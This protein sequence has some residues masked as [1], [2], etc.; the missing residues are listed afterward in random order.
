M[1]PAGRDHRIE[2]CR[3]RQKC[4]KTENGKECPHYHHPLLHKSIVVKIG[5][6]SLSNPQETLLPV[7]TCTIYG[8][9]G[10]QKQGNTLLDS[11]AQVSLIRE[12][13]AATLG[14]KGKDTSITITKVGEEEETIKTKV[15]K[16][17]VSSPDST[18]MFSIKAISIPC[19]SEDVSAVQL[20][21]IAKLL[22]LENE[23][24]R[25]GNGPVDLLI[26]IDHA[27]MHTGLRKQTDQLVVR[28]TPLG[29]V[30]FGGPLGDAQVNGRVYH[31]RF[32]APVEMSDFWKTETMGVE[33]KPC[34]CAADKLTQ[35]EREEAE[36][37]SKSCEKIG[38]QWMIPY[39]WKKDPVLLPDNKS[40]AMKRLEA[41][42]R[43]LKKDPEQGMAYDKQ[44]EEMKE[45]QFSRKLSKQE[46]DNYKGPVHYIPHH[47]VIRPEK[48]STPV[49][50][51]F[52]SSSVYQGHA[53]NDYWL[54]GPDLLNNLFG[55]ILRF[56]Q[57]E[58]AVMGD[59]SKMYHRV[60]IPERDQHVH[61][62]LWRNLETER[63]PDVYVKTVLTF[64]DKPAPAMAQTALRK[65]AEENK[66]DHPEAAEALTKNSYMD[67]ICGSVD[68]VMQAQK[69]TGDLDKVLESGGFGVK[70]WTSNKALT[71][72]EDQERGLKVFQKEVEE[73][74]LGVVWNYHTDEFSF[75]VKLDLLRM[76]DRSIHLGVKM[77]KRTLLSQ[78][79]RFY[80]P[81]G[82]AAAFV[83]RA[84][85]SMQELWQIGLDWD[86]ELPDDVQERWIQLFKEMQELDKIGF[87]RCL[88]P[89]ESSELP[90]LCVFS[91]ASQEA[92]VACAYIHQRRNEDTYS[93]NFVA[94]K[95]RVAPLKQL[96][97]PR[98]ELQAAVLASRLAKTIV[99]ECTIQF[100]DIKFFTDSSITLAWIQ[101]PSRSFKPFVSSRVGEIQ[102]N[103]DPSQWRHISGED[104]VADDLSRGLHVQQ[105]TGRWMN[106]PEF[107]KL[108][109]EQWPV[110]TATPHREED[111]ERR[112]VNAVSSVSHADV[113][114][115]IDV[116]N[117]T[118]W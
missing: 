104:N 98:L 93:V 89:S 10:F 69:L 51:V 112:Q 22:G 63:E 116:K 40:L 100:A 92:F 71:K 102:S 6:A 96:T 5:V 31:V 58:V 85:I 74:V 107:L 42:E 101:S 103:S 15:Y 35:A 12:E 83:I 52:N 81:I 25:R 21:P 17:P 48:K 99:E 26:G 45:M 77:T 82:F 59:I 65:T 108:P 43:R 14:L 24:I 66:N 28:N 18:K 90:V 53:L 75:K 50:I 38:N 4:T 16:V 117:F 115:I 67:D 11:G 39:P 55:V 33:V 23:R 114:K 91:D 88:V 9:N 73:K 37:I 118:R 78:V 54:K 57:K 20:K 109:E 95:S 60:L 32:A 84:K 110:Q 1:K 97:I 44:M 80:D 56:R 7:I 3:R 41:T 68:T 30:V 49:R 70:G 86:D 34:V 106:S 111:M 94:A 76:T 2:N 87:K 47:A 13:T 8:Q 105:L 113:G 64:G 19:I 79:A 27:Q 46:M 62:F 61:R 29:W 72:A 36:I